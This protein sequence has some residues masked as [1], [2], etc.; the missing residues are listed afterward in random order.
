MAKKQ[1]KSTKGQTG[2]DI[3]TGKDVIPK[4]LIYNLPSLKIIL[5]QIL[6]HKDLGAHLNPIQ[7]ILGILETTLFANENEEREQSPMVF[8]K[9]LRP[10]L[11]WLRQLGILILIDLNDLPILGS[12][13]K[14]TLRNKNKH[15]KY[16][17]ISTKRQG[18]GLSEESQSTSKQRKDNYPSTGVVYRRKHKR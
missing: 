4:N 10:V 7:T 5:Q 8:R 6:L 14:G 13:K 3:A 17:P 1:P 12:T 16:K 18:Q 15:K 11:R 2:E 9:M